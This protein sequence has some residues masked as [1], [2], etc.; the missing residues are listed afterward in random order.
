VITFEQ[1]SKR[2]NHR[3]AGVSLRDGRVLLHRAETEDFWTLPGGRVELLEPSAEA[4]RREMQEELGIEVEVERLLWVVENFFEY[5]KKAYHELAFYFLVSFPANS[6]LYDKPAFQG[7]EEGVRLL[8]QWFPL[9]TLET[10]RL[11]PSFL[12]AALQ[13]LPDAVTHVVHFDT[14]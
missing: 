14:A 2:F 11:Y 3:V 12:R 8:F 6:P 4:L 5:D 13:I 1:D 7:N 9:D 10:V